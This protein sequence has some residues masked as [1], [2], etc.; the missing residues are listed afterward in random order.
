M[1]NQISKKTKSEINRAKNSWIWN[2][3]ELKELE[4][5]KDTSEDSHN[6]SNEEI[7][8]VLI[9]VCQYKDTPTSPPCGTTYI[10]KDSS[11]GNAISHLRSKHDISK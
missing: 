9:I 5:V 11:T 2:Y 8:K 6:D 10:R 7:E 1:V 4:I 3:F